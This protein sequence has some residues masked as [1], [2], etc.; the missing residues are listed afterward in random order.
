MAVEEMRY[1]DMILTLKEA[2]YTD[3]SIALA[4][5]SMLPGTPIP[6]INSVRRWRYGSTQP[7][8]YYAALLERLY[9]EAVSQG[10]VAKRSQ[11]DQ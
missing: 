7:S 8:P 3:A 11:N 1:R 9:A 5:A 6:S 4:L 2:G 10:I